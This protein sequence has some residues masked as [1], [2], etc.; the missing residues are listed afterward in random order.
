MM[1]RIFPTLYAAV[2]IFAAAIPSAQAQSFSANLGVTNNYMWRGI[3][4]TDDDFAV[5][6]GVDFEFD[7]GLSFGAWASNVD[8]GAGDIELDIYGGYSFPITDMLSGS[9]GGIAYL[10]P[11]KPNGVDANF[12]EFNGGL[13]VDLSPVTLSGSIAFSPDVAGETT[14]DFE[15]GASIGFAEYFEV[16]GTL[17]YYEW[18]VTDGWLYYVAG[19][20]ASYENFGISAYATGTDISGDDTEFVVALTI[21]VP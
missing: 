15:G 4:Q 12:F 11:D 1:K 21:T 18:E 6:G 17:G 3:T 20:G 7:N 14:W 13:E 8:W 5:Q 9:V 19:V 16:F 2:G 10:Y